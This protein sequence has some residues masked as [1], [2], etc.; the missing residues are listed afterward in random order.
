MSERQDDNQLDRRKFLALL[1]A[2]GA[3]V[4]P[5][6]VGLLHSQTAVAQT[7][8][9]SLISQALPPTIA[10]SLIESSK[11]LSGSESETSKCVTTHY[12]IADTFIRREAPNTNEGANPLIRVG[13]EPVS[14]GLV[15][16]NRDQVYRSYFPGASAQLVLH[17][18]N[19]HNNWGQFDNRTVSVFPLL[20]SFAEGNG[21][22]SG[23]PGSQAVRGTGAGATWNSPEDPNVFD[24]SVRG[25]A[26]QWRGGERVG[27]RTAPPVVHINQVE[28][29]DVV[30][31]VT[32]D[33]A[34]GLPIVGWLIAV[35]AEMDGHDND[36]E[37]EGKRVPNGFD[38]NEG[39]TVEY[40][41][42]E[43]AA[44]AGFP[45]TWGPRLIIG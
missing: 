11:S 29:V 37:Q 34:S 22:Q 33:L 30:W 7:L 3:Y 28:G 24:N 25:A 16:F 20:E 39:G 8:S 1:G 2:A 5:A 42:N 32:A 6:L 19:N 15:L 35:D 13:V 23:L 10:C 45:L 17:I 40:Y 36:D 14:R 31:D 44:A 21:K 26:R 41:S 38:R 12:A 9:S 18:A 43:G 27:D 4:P